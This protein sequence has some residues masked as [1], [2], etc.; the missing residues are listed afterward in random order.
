MFVRFFSILI[1]SDLTSL[2]FGGLCNFGVISEK[3]LSNPRSQKF[4]PGFS[5]KSFMIL[6]LSFRSTIHS[7]VLVFLYGVKFGVQIH[8]LQVDFQLFQAIC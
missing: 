8:N 6:G 1:W 5:S 4:I 3:S 7:L 2:H